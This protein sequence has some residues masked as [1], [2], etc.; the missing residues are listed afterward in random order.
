MDRENIYC[1][2][3]VILFVL[4]ICGYVNGQNLVPNGGFNYPEP[5]IPGS[6][7]AAGMTPWFQSHGT[8]DKHHPCYA[9]TLSV[10]LNVSGWETSYEGEGYVGLHTFVGS[11]L[12]REYISV[13]L[14]EPLVAGVAYQGRFHVSRSDSC[15]YATGQI[16]M[17]LSSEF[18]SSD[19]VDLLSFEPQVTSTRD[20]I[21]TESNGWTRINRSFVAEGG[22]RYLTI[23]NFKDDDE[24][25]TLFVSGGGQLP[26]PSSDYWKLAYYYVDAVSVVPD[27]IYL[28]VNDF[29]LGG[30]EMNLYPNPNA[31]EFM[32]D[33]LIDDNDVAEISV[34]NISGQ[35]IYKEQLSV[36]Q[37]QL[38]LAV[39]NGLYLY[40]V[41]LNG[42]PEWT[43]KVSIGLD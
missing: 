4:S 15:W 39:A 28:S 17:Y 24:T 7:T 10:P 37:N 43:G 8:P 36:G 40:V 5:C 6:G 11:N 31:G 14:M 42:K 41:T 33:L 2:R 12:S 13:E 18:P 9:S 29:E 30:A 21:L 32:I 27:S 3:L 19:I 26:F 22:E 23:G 34:W 35:R 16:G 20:S 38:E 1:L 25:D